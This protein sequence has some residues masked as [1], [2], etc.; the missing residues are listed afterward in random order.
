[1]EVENNSKEK[2][3]GKYK[4]LELIGKGTYG[5]VYKALH[6]DTKEIVALKKTITRVNLL[7]L[8]LFNQK[9]ITILINSLKIM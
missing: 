6:L 8:Y 4:T 7:L 2:I 9:I 5:E 3:I 1:M